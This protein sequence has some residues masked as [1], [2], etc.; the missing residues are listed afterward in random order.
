MSATATCTH[1][2]WCDGQWVEAT[3]VDAPWDEDD[4]WAWEFKNA[5]DAILWL[6][7]A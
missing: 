2:L 1:L 7:S 4:G 3:K 5:E 6:R